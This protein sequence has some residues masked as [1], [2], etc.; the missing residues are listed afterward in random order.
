MFASRKTLVATALFGLGVCMTVGALAPFA[1]S[2]RVSGTVNDMNLAARRIDAAFATVT[3]ERATSTELAVRLGKGDLQVKSGCADQKW[4]DIAP[5][6]LV[7]RNR[8]AHPVRMIT[9][10]YQTGNATSVLVRMPAPEV[11]SR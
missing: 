10:G 7:G 1:A 6:C 3:S 9:I 4:P 2:A 8:A 11:A 5:E